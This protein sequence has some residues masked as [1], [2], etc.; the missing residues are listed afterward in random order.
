MAR[1]KLILP[2]ADAGDVRGMYV[3]HATI[4]V[5]DSSANRRTTIIVKHRQP[6]CYISLS[7]IAPT[8]FSAVVLI[9]M[10]RIWCDATR[11]AAIAALC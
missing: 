3:M 1:C 11:N 8:H 5:C 2:R 10:P 9:I 4:K 6:L 7:A